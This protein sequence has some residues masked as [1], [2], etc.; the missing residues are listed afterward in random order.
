M[1]LS[2]RWVWI[3]GAVLSIGV[4]GYGY[5]Y[6]IP[7]TGGAPGPMQNPFHAPWL[8]VHAGLAATA[9]LIG[10]FQL[11]PFLRTRR[12]RLHRWMGRTYVAACLIGGSAGLLLAIGTTAGPI[13]TAGFGGLAVVWIAVTSQAWRLA[14]ARRFVEHRRW[15][16]RSFALTFAAVTL[17]IYLPIATFG[18]HMD[19]MTAYRAISWLAWVPN[20]IVA[21]L[22][23]AG[24]K[25]TAVPIAA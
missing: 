17:R 8:Y 11:W 15:M 2:R 20:L 10:P 13:A 7:G 16:I 14:Q 23:L 9:L 3:I 24:R 18:L 19:F 5:R 12:P 4:A 25:T 6:L 21:E 22:Y 1:S